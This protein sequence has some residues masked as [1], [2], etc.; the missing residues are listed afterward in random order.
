MAAYLRV[1]EQDR[2]E[3]LGI[4][5]KEINLPGGFSFESPSRA[6]ARASADTLTR[7][8]VNEIPKKITDVTLGSLETGASSVMLKD[9]RSQFI[10]NA[11][12]LAILDLKFDDVPA[13]PGIRT[14]AEC[15]YAAS[16]KVVM[17]PTV[18]PG[19]LKER[20]PRPTFSD[21]RIENYLRMMSEI[22][23]QIGARNN[24]AI[25]GTVPLVPPKFSR[26]ILKLYFSKEIEAFAIDAGTKDILNNEVDFQLILEEIKKQKSLSEVFVYA[27]NLGYPQFETQY[28]RADDFLSIFAHVDVLGGTFKTR[29]G[30]IGVGQLKPPKPKAKIFLKERY[31]YE[32]S[33]FEKV[34]Q[35][36]GRLLS[37]SEL[38]NHNQ[39][40]QLQEAN[41]VR[42]LVGQESMREYISAKPSVD[43]RSLN[44][45]M[46]IAKGVA[47]A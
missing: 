16:D 42:S 36:L 25:M 20:S 28:A 29:G 39:M 13:S 34:G 7:V 14:I 43:D 47:R 15:L 10:E 19:L 38:Q 22:I 9:I 24:K 41:D 8:V 46:S 35:K 40:V 30:P 5:R 37:R 12:N 44:D 11:L 4:I 2:D 18:K 31:A 33:T 45:L 21:A 1:R 23:E 17:L 3:E 32:M 27:C 6:I 26:R